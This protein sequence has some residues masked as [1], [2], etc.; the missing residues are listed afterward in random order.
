MPAEDRDRLFEN[1]LARHLR[2]DAGA[3]DAACPDPDL[4]AAYHERM[5]SPEEMI[6][7]KEH[8]VSCARCQEI[9]AQLEATEKVEA[10]RKSEADLVVSAVGSRSNV[11]EIVEE[12]ESVPVA[13]PAAQK[14]LEKIAPFPARKNSLLRWAAPAGAIA[15]GLLLWIGVRE[16]HTHPKLPGQSTQIA[17]NRDQS[18]RNLDAAPAAPRPNEKEKAERSR[19]EEAYPRQPDGLPVAKPSEQ[20]KTSRSTAN[21]DD[22]EMQ[23][24]KTPS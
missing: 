8:L 18:S 16:F 13:I 6:V 21:L 24:K 1:A 12:S 10:L 17:E 14:P 22:R 9:L 7:A 5:L 15:A 4:L 23:D 3:S 11:M 20:L 2:S 19:H